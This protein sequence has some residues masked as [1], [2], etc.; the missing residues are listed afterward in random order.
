MN[1]L[2]INASAR[3]QAGSASSGR[4][5]AEGRVPA[6]VY[7]KSK[8]PENLSLDARELRILLR[9]I[10]NNT[11]VVQLKSGE[12]EARTSIIKEVQR[13]PMKDSYTHVDFQEI[14]E[15]EVVVLEVPVHHKGEA[16]GVKNEGGT[17]ET[18]SH[19]VSIR[20]LAKDI[21]S[22]IDADVRALKVGDNLHVSQ[23]PKIEGVEYLDAPEQPVFAI[24]K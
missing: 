13:H 17:I 9:S 11:P 7:G 23:L 1:T 4:L 18:V 12:G 8:E 10:G 21:P 14:A 6:V 19:T 24:V 2:T 5:R 22:S 20:C 3:E 15:G 16:D